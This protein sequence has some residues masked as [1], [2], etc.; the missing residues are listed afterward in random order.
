ML[1]RYLK[2]IGNTVNMGGET[3]VCSLCLAA[4]KYINGM[5]PTNRIN[6]VSAQL[7]QSCDF[8]SENKTEKGS[9]PVGITPKL[10]GDKCDV[11][12]TANLFQHMKS[13]LKNKLIPL[14][15]PSTTRL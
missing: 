8:C 1:L 4:K 6:D 12:W 7:I 5:S 15:F 13:N 11:N 3:E 10:L 14:K 2:D 9:V